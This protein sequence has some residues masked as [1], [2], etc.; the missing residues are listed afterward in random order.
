MA[1]QQSIQSVDTALAILKTMADMNRAMTLKEI[2]QAADMTASNTHRYMVSFM[3]AGLAVQELDTGRYDLGP[4]A[5]HVGLSA[6]AR[7]DAV[8][9]ATKVLME[10]RAEVDLPVTLSMWTQ[11]GPTTIRWLDASQPLTV[12]VKA[13]SRSPL[14]TSASGRVF[15]AFKDEEETRILLAAELKLRRSRK[16]QTLVTMN[17]V[18]ALLVEVRRHRIGR[19][20]GER[21][22]GV[23][24]LSAPVFNA[25]DEAVLSI[26]AVGLTHT[27]DASY[28]GDLARAVRA[29]AERAS[30][31]L[32]YRPQRTQRSGAQDKG[33]LEQ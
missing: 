19:V 1:E 16:E 4:T 28:D 13:G 30:M 27:I 17:E 5:I 29:A 24:A 26:A 10:L 6:M 31:L 21:V 7:S 8:A 32:G 33:Q 12:N 15:L 20:M 25:H 14:L 23:S 11:E 3:R 9:V 22:P 2:A 18:Q